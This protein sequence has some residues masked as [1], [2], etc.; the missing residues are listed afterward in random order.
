[1]ILYKYGSICVQ[2]RSCP[3]ILG[4]VSWSVG[5]LDS[6]RDSLNSH[7]EICRCLHFRYNGNKGQSS[8]PPKK[9]TKC[10]HIPQLQP[11]HYSDHTT[12]SIPC[13][14]KI[15][16]FLFYYLSKPPLKLN[17]SVFSVYRM[18]ISPLQGGRSLQVIIRLPSTSVVE[19]TGNY[20]R[21]ASRK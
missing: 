19:K 21:R 4:C 11:S 18:F 1:M 16:L 10:S 7:V 14:G 6:S 12:C 5:D 17:R 3:I 9:R 20:L 2:Y 8:P 13:F 15:F